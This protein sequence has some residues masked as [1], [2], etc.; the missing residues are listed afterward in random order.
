M[1]VSTL[2][3]LIC[4]PCCVIRQMKTSVDNTLMSEGRADD[5]NVERTVSSRCLQIDRRGQEQC[6]PAAAQPFEV[7]SSIE[8]EGMIILSIPIV[9]VGSRPVDLR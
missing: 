4:K 6:P 7:R 9:P 5:A 1:S 3:Q 8:D 2:M